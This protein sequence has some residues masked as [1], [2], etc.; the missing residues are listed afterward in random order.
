MKRHPIAGSVLALIGCSVGSN[1]ISVAQPP[2][3]RFGIA[4]ILSAPVNDPDR[5]DVSMEISHD[6]QELY[7]CSTGSFD[8]WVA[9]RNGANDF[10]EP[11]WVA[12]GCDPSLSTDGLTLFVSRSGDLFQLTRP[13]PDSEWGEAES[14]GASI[15]TTDSETGPNVSP[16]GKTLYFLRG[17]PG[18]FDDVIWQTQRDDETQPFGPP[19]KV[20]GTFN[21]N[22]VFSVE[23]TQDNL[24]LFFSASAGD[25]Y[26]V[27]RQSEADDWSRPQFLSREINSL[28]GYEW[29]TSLS[30]DETTLYFDRS[31]PGADPFRGPY[32]IWR[33]PILPSGDFDRSWKLDAVD[34]DL[35]TSAVRG[36]NHPSA[37]DVDG[38]GLVDDGDRTVWIHDIRGTWFGDANLDGEFNSTDLVEILAAG[39][40]ESDVDAGWASGDFNASERFDSGD[41]IDALADGG[42]EQGP[43]PAVAAVPEPASWVMLMLGLTGDIFGRRRRGPRA[44]TS[45]GKSD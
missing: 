44:L 43:R 29:S 5:I 41:L 10:G 4:T 34:I 30:A 18:E 42:Y 20:E 12:A 31:P 2:P 26:V 15:S 23:V 1:T 35:L 36:Q 40:Y 21:K 16:D 9:R 8:T 32:D 17:T 27:S 14:L 33:G 22:G 6:G 11:E 13:S 37:F 45:R 39:T 24:A 3:M 19:V 28:R 25:M 38:N 7:Y